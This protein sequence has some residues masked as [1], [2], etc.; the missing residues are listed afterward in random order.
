MRTAHRCLDGGPDE[1]EGERAARPYVRSV[2]GNPKEKEE[3][4]SF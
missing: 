3:K 1:K 4:N 2:T